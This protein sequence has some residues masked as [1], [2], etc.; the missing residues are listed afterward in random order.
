MTPVA[1][2][3]GGSNWYEQLLARKM[4]QNQYLHT[5]GATAIQ[6]MLGTMTLTYQH[7]RNLDYRIGHSEQVAISGR[8]LFV[9]GRRRHHSDPL[10]R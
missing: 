1:V 8:T 6:V 7:H 5:H 10:V 9:L 3:C 4:L 2:I